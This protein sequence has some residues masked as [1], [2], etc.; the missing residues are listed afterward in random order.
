MNCYDFETGQYSTDGTAILGRKCYCGTTGCMNYQSKNSG[1]QLP[2][3][4]FPFGI[5]VDNKDCDCE[6]E[7]TLKDGSICEKCQDKF[8]KN[9]FKSKLI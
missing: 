1:I 2:I 5:N 4:Q 3:G 8:Y 7:W 6:Y 9:V